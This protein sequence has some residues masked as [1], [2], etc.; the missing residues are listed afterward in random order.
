MYLL[1]LLLSALAVLPPAQA[2]RR[3]AAPA[4]PFT[5]PLTLAQMSNKQAVVETTAG[6]FV[7]D[8]RPDL[9]PNHV[10]YFMK[11]ARE[12]AYANTLFHRVV[13]HAIIQ[14]GDPLSRD[15]SKA[16][17]VGSGGLGV[18]Q[19]EHSGE[20]FTRGAVGAAL[21]PGQPD[22][23]GAQFFV[24]VTEQPALAGQFTVFGRV[25]EGLDIVQK[26]SEVP[27]DG[28]GAPE[29]RVA[30]TAV[31]IRDTPPPEP[32]PFAN[33]T[34]EQLAQHR[35]VLETSLG[36]ITIAF[37]PGVAPEHVRNFLQLAQAGVLD[38]TAFH[39]VVRG[40]V[41]QTGALNTRGPLTEKQQK[42]VHNLQ[43]EFNGTKHV[44]GIV[45]MA[46]GDDPASA[47]TSFFIVTAD[48]PTLDGKYTVFGRVIEG[49]DV[50]D[51][52]ETTSVSGESPTTRIDLVKVRI[53]G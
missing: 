12:G 43:P 48:A 28:K 40:F 47:T 19:A 5:T 53:A 23:G 25:S 49:L 9:A 37:T 17:Q 31:A 42:L 2:Q 13:R 1:A 20:P 41:V 24:C 18:L 39:R 52:I 36:P 21:R 35:A 29:A 32:V 11:L 33:E 4:A 50:L 7:I 45:S 30:I 3:P 27:A 15:P 51:R 8:L 16:A 26:I 38:G 34:P 14:G 46:R 44:K 22:S 6:A 10:G